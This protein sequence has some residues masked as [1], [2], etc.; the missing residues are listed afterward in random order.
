MPLRATSI[1]PLSAD[2]QSDGLVRELR[3]VEVLERIGGPEAEE[4]LETLVQGAAEA[5]LTREACAALRRLE[6][7]LWAEW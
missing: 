4:V 2:P 6:Q 3:A 7:R 5:R 1:V